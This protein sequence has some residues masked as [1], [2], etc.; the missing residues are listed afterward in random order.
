MTRTALAFIALMN[1]IVLTS[2]VINIIVIMR[3][4]NYNN[5]GV[6]YDSAYLLAVWLGSFCW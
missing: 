4:K 1:T 6:L 3:P 5:R 2:I